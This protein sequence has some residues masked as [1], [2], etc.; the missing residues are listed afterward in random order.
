MSGSVVMKW[1]IP[2]STGMPCAAVESCLNDSL[3]P[4]NEYANNRDD[5]PAGFMKR[6]LGP[7]LTHKLVLCPSAISGPNLVVMQGSACCCK[8]K[9]LHDFQQLD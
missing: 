8:Q 3:V 9:K 6:P 7:V 5:M 2:L 4:Q 1:C